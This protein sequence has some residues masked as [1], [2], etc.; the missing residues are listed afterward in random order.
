MIVVLILLMSSFV[1]RPFRQEQRPSP[2]ENIFKSVEEVRL[3]VIKQLARTEDQSYH[4]VGPTHLR[5]QI[6]N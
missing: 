1:K 2:S 5:S 3:P 4:L 6:L